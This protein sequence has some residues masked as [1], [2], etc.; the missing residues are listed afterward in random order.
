MEDDAMDLSDGMGCK[1]A[2]AHQTESGQRREPLVVSQRPTGHRVQMTEQGQ[3][4]LATPDAR[5]DQRPDVDLDCV[6]PCAAESPGSAEGG[7]DVVGERLLGLREEVDRTA[8][9][10]GVRGPAVLAVALEGLFG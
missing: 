8:D 10:E 4:L 2:L 3:S 5:L 9:S 6:D 7:S 1:A